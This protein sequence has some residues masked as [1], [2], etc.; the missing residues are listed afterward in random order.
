M[1]VFLLPPQNLT[2]PHV[3]ITG[4]LLTHIRDSLRVRA[5]EQL[6]VG[7]GAG[8]RYRIE[9]TA[10][11]K[12]AVTGRILESM[13]QPAR[14]TPSLILGQALLKGDKMDWVIQKATELGVATVLPVQTRHSVVQPK[15]DRIEA[16]VARWQRIAL[17]AA[18][19]SERWIVSAVGAPQTVPALCATA[20]QTLRIILT[21]RRET[22]AKIDDLTWPTAPEASVAVLVGPEGGWSEEEIVV[23]EQ[24][25]FCLVT[26][27]PTILRAE[28]AAIAAIAILQQKLGAL[29]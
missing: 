4:E 19:Q 11:A 27:G 1:P 16:Q 7:D 24:A 9:V 3:S 21:E 26:L 14:T 12:K 29:N 23:A 2:P 28:T 22:G 15:A 8:R 25:G 6:L 10:V 5:G 18:Q 13:E 17:E 20:K